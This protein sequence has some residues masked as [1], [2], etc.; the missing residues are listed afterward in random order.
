MKIKGLVWFGTRTPYFDEMKAF[1]QQIS[2]L[3]PAYQTEDFAMFTLPNGDRLE[4]FGASSPDSAF[5]THPVAGFLVEDIVAARAELEMMGIELVG[6]IEHAPKGY[7]WTHFRA[8]DGFVYELTENPR[9][10]LNQS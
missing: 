4:V 7:S 5:M 2:G 3:D 10:P 6:P 8:P 1:F 9:H